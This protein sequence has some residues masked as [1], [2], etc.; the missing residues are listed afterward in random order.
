MNCRHFSKF[1]VI[2]FDDAS[3]IDEAQS[4]MALLF[5]PSAVI[6]FGDPC[7]KAMDPMGIEQKYPKHNL[8]QS[9]FERI[10]KSRRC[11]LHLDS[12]YRFGET[13]SRFVSKYLYSGLSV[14]CRKMQP[15]KTLNGV[16][17]YHRKND[18]F[19]FGF[20]KN[21]LQHINPKQYSYGILHP[22]NINRTD[23]ETDSL[24]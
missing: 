5:S 22:P 16:S 12:Q 9:M 21:M 13:I 6:L 18:G 4:T 23:I 3:E 1:D 17:I 7:K 14:G 20:I 11:V 2:L 24:G 15:S 19:C 10:R 8:N